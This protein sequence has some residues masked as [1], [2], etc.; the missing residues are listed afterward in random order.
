MI[1]NE[2]VRKAFFAQDMEILEQYIEFLEGKEDRLTKFED[3]L[4]QLKDQGQKDVLKH[5]EEFKAQ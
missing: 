1:R 3:K 4:N 2:D 5:F